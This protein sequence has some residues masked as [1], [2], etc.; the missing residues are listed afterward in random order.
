MKSHLVDSKIQKPWVSS[1]NFIF[2][3]G[4]VERLKDRQKK[5]L[6]LHATVGYGKTVL[7]THYA[8]GTPENCSWYHLSDTD[9]DIAVFMQ[10]LSTSLKRS[11][12]DFD[13]DPEAYAPLLQEKEAV[14]TMAHD[15]VA[16]LEKAVRLPPED[17]VVIFD[18]FQAI[19]NEEIH[20]IIQLILATAKI[21][22]ILATKGSIPPFYFR[23][24]LEGTAELITQKD[25]CFAEEEVQA[26]MERFLGKETPNS[27]AG[28]IW[29]KAEG[30][31][32]GVMFANL[33]LKQKRQW[34]KE[35]E[36]DA[37]YAKS[38]VNTYFMHEIFKKLP[39]EIQIF[40]TRTS[41]LEFL[42]S[43][44]CNAVLQI[45]NAQS[46]F[47]YLEREN[48]FIIKVGQSDGEFRYHSLFKDFLAA[49][50]RRETRQ[51]ILDRAAE[52]YLHTSN[53][54]QAVE[55]ALAG[56]NWSLMQY[57]LEVVGKELLDEGKLTTLTRWLTELEQAPV[58]MTPK[59]LLLAGCHCYRSGQIQKAQGYLDKA[60]ALF[61]SSMDE[62]GY[63]RCMVEK[64]RIAR[65][66]VS[67]EESCRLIEDVLPRLHVRYGS[68]WYTVVGERLY[69]FI[70]LG[71]YREVL[72]I[73]SEMILNARREGN[74]KAEGYFIRFSVVV[75][76]YLGKYQKGLKLYHN[77][78]ERKWFEREA[79]DAFSVE[80]Y[81]ALMY[82][83]TGHKEKAQE[84]IKVELERKT[85]GHKGEDMWLVYL[86][87]AY[88]SF[89][90]T[91]GEGTA[92]QEKK[93]LIQE[94]ERSIHMAQRYVSTFREDH[95]FVKAVQV[96]QEIILFNPLETSLAEVAD[97]IFKEEKSTVPL[98]REMALASLASLFYDAG[99]WNEAKKSALA[100]L[101]GMEWET[102]F[103]AFA[104]LV[105][106]LVYRRE[107]REEEGNIQFK[108][109]ED[110]ALEN[111]LAWS[112]LPEQ[113]KRDI[114]ELFGQD[115]D[116]EDTGK[117]TVSCFGDFRVFLSD[118]G[119]EIQWRTKKAQALFAYLFHL[120][121]R[122]VDKDVLLLQLWPE[123]DKKSATTL[124][125]TTLY[126]IRK[127]LAAY[128]LED[129]ISYQNKRYAMKMELVHSDLEEMDQLCQALEHGDKVFVHGRGDFLK[130]YKG[131]YL[132]GVTGNF[133]ES[134]KAY[135]EK[136]F[137]EICRLLAERTMKE[138]RFED[139]V[140][141]LDRAI[142][143]DP[144]G[145]DLYLLVL[146][147]LRALGEVKRAKR[148][149]EQI[150]RVLKEDLDVEPAAEVTGAYR[151]CLEEGSLRKKGTAI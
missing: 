115:K 131:S 147:C 75:Y 31:P 70:F 68:W 23:Y 81:V 65:H 91:R 143:V 94:A 120:Q 34:S 45:D 3:E 36:L 150:V 85:Q 118:Q 10:Y 122:P 52:F 99:E 83:C 110:Y 15:F 82:L 2:R 12:P 48:L 20:Q 144:Y 128:R 67:L 53:K 63:I 107:G 133:S 140:A 87:Q 86:L 127:T 22:L 16:Q 64:A 17:L 126:S 90:L 77:L 32:A 100:C 76:F 66:E 124:L 39:Y 103:S 38:A 56:G 29:E 33:Y 96:A 130:C 136:K 72:A 57:A 135:Y 134:R 58:P 62:W 27:L 111:Q 7:L 50:L 74:Q 102:P 125:H 21:R 123:A 43:E 5:L 51:E 101:E 6:V 30:W 93:N 71:R 13:F 44:V 142:A 112:L 146:Q 42:S 26:L 97:R 37:I 145:E 14:K 105:L 47:D 9:N 137:L 28:A 151:N 41:P 69:N 113:E 79:E 84:T 129:L 104:R 40:L 19:E 60:L 141:Y 54:E 95:V 149:Y 92:P 25:L 35:I 117:V 121:G 49:Q 24:F 114:R 108:R 73:C 106:A 138:G 116:R 1:A 119:D 18:D 139:A 98:A 46:I 88:I 109:Q 4:L 148:Y 8:Q 78:L 89:L 61:V 132:G 80:A 59:N 55:Y 11:L